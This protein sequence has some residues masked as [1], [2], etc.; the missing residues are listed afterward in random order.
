MPG[1]QSVMIS[2]AYQMETW[3]VHSLDTAQVES[4][5]M[6]RVTQ[7]DILASYPQPPVLHKGLHSDKELGAS[8]LTT[9]LVLALRP[10]CL[11]VL[12][13]ESVSITV[14]TLRMPEWFAQEV[15]HMYYCHYN[16]IAL[17]TWLLLQ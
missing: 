11:T 5:I 15:F 4:D 10:T 14:L 8:F 6:I 2:G 12:T 17:Y 9:L 3:C 16:G 13:M 1:V 7:N